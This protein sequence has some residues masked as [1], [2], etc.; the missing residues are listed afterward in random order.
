MLHKKQLVLQKGAANE[1][2]QHGSTGLSEAFTSSVKVLD[3]KLLMQSEATTGAFEVDMKK[4][5]IVSPVEG[6]ELRRF[7]TEN[8]P[9]PTYCE[10]KR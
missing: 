10:K 8:R 9:Q 5:P 7:I 1:D 6:T 4:N 2:F 3:E